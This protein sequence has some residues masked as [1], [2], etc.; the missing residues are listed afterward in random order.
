MSSYKEASEHAHQV[1]LIKEFE[2]VSPQYSELL[3]AIPNGGKRSIKVA[4]E[5]K[6]EGVKSGVPDMMLAV[7][8]GGYHGLF[9]ELKKIGGR[10][11]ANQKKWQ[12][13]LRE[14]GYKSE[15]IEGW[16]NALA[17][18]MDYLNE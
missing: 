13:Q 3:F 15:V 7:A 4:R 8:R 10:A 14:Q 18:L 5:L 16:Y 2:R 1:T 9:I 11:N 12:K 17:V 6:L